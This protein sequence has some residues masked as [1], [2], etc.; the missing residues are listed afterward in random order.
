MIEC[1]ITS[2][3]AYRHSSAFG[4]SLGPALGGPEISTATIR[5]ARPRRC[6]N[7]S[8]LVAPP[9]TRICPSCNTGRMMVGSAI[10]AASARRSGP[11][12]NATSVRR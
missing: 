4:T 2:T 9:S 1:V 12:E 11:S 7:G 5:S 6:S 8:G 10:E 3:V